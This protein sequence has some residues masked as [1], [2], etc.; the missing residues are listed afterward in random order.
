MGL[1]MGSPI[2]LHKLKQ[3]ANKDPNVAGYIKNLISSIDR[4]KYRGSLN[5]DKLNVSN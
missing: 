3:I 4:D 5:L 2:R 1:L